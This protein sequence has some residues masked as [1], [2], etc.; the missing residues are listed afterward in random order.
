MV[1][2]AADP[3]VPAPEARWGAGAARRVAL[4]GVALLEAAVA[5]V[6]QVAVGVAVPVASVEAP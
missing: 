4:A 3:E 5:L 1:E 6:V 2:P